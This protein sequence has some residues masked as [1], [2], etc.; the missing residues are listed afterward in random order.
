M[1]APDPVTGR[2]R[3]PYH[4]STLVDQGGPHAKPHSDIDVDGG[5]MDGFIRAVVDGP[6][7]MR[8]HPLA[9]GLRRAR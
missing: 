1:C 3:E 7:R 5:K 2:V 6:E 8:R 4:D 9:G